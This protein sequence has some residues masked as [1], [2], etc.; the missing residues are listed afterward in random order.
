M[1]SREQLMQ[2]IRIQTEI[3]KLG[4]DLGGVMQ[5][6]VEQILSL[7]EADGAAIELA[8]KDEMVYR[9]A[10]GIAKSQLGLRLKMSASL[11]GLCVTRGEPL[12]CTDS[13]TDPL[14]DRLACQKVGLRSM[15]V[16][17]LKHRGLPAGVLKAMSVQPDRFKRSDVALLEML[18][19]VVAAA[20]YFSVKY[21]NDELF[22]KAT[23]DG[24]T[25][26]ANRALFMDRLRNAVALADRNG[27][28]SGVL[29][30]DLD[31]LKEINDTCGHRTGD[32][33]ILEFSTRLKK[34]TR[35][36]D[37]AARLGGDEFGVVLTQLED[38]EGIYSA[39]NR[40][41]TEIAPSLHFEN[42]QYQLS[43]SIGCAL[44]PQDGLEPEK[45]MEV[46]DQR[47]YL[48]KQGRKKMVSRP[49][50]LILE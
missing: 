49:S 40:L 38:S 5:F 37:T 35:Q 29:M 6:I 14:V 48:A 32:A 8:E 39:A 9:A 24:M 4:L 12:S 30:I 16:I 33:I 41:E 18:S 28:L 13:E 19:E 43:A 27:C 26:L 3:A 15:I 31:G 36:T 7:I 46:A 34:V 20:M 25:G 1:P 45:I 47:M 23:H 21:D 17:P 50:T 11:S 44:I 10:S 42:K 22:I 2:V